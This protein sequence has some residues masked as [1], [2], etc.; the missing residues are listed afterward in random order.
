MKPKMAAN[1]M[2]NGLVFL[3][4]LKTKAIITKRVGRAEKGLFG[5]CQPVGDG[6]QELRIDYG[7]GFRVY[8]GVDEN[9]ELIVLLLGGSK[10]G[11]QTD[12]VPRCIG[13]TIKREKR[14]RKMAAKNKKFDSHEDLLSE[15]LKDPKFASEYLSSFLPFEDEIDEELFLEAM[16]KLVEACGAT[17]FSKETDVARR[18]AYTAFSKAGNPQFKTFTAA[19]DYFGLSFQIVPKNIVS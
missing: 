11:Q 4:I 7:P 14:R 9:N 18:T 15:Q 13:L 2:L 1:P 17:K 6:V 10:K 19:L 12:I 3:K 16:G 5:D 8:F